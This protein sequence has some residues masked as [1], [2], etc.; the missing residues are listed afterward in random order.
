MPT[1]EEYKALGVG[2][3]CPQCLAVR[4]DMAKLGDATLDDVGYLLIK[5]GKFGEF[6]ACSDWCGYTRSVPGR[7]YFPEPEKKGICPRCKDTHYIPFIKSDGTMSQYAQVICPDCGGYDHAQSYA[8]ANM[9]DRQPDDYDFTCSNTWRS[10]YNGERNTPAVTA[11]EQVSK[12]PAE[13]IDDRRW[14]SVQQIIGQ[15][16]F[17]NK[18]VTEM[19][20]EK[21]KSR[22]RY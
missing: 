8:D 9:P 5:H 11:D 15:V 7:S 13:T 4:A 21:K 22:G 6:I 14:A 2:G 12:V 3:P 17:L 20:I 1:S 16:R 19:R 18:K 10:Y